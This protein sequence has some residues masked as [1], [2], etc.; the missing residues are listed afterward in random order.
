MSPLRLTIYGDN[1]LVQAI[2]KLDGDRLTI[3]HFAR[4]QSG[5]PESFDDHRDEFGSLF[6]TE[7]KRAQ[8][9]AA[10]AKAPVEN[11]IMAAV[12]L[13]FA[14]AADVMKTVAT[15]EFPDVKIDADLRTNV[16]IVSLA[17]DQREQILALIRELDRPSSVLTLR[18]ANVEADTAALIVRKTFASDQN[19]PVSVAT[20][21]DDKLIV[22]GA[23]DDVQQQIRNLL[24]SLEWLATSAE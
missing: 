23:S 8:R 11:Q 3:A 20:T 5:P 13:R 2:F 19:T 10:H 21:V 22:R 18:I 15:M 9:D 24:S 7:L 1:V 16:I 12:P 6:L 4:S 17:A 14:N